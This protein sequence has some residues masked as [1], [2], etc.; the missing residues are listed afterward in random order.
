MSP[1][2]RHHGWELC[3]DVRSARA[4][5]RRAILIAAIESGA[6]ARVAIK[7][8]GVSI[9]TAR[10]YVRGLGLRIPQEIRE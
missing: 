10:R 1:L 8:A 3:N 7:R 4:L 5:Q 6:P 2:A 9:R